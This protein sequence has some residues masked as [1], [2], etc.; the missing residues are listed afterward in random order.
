M[1]GMW[2]VQPILLVT[3]F[4]YAFG[5]AVHLPGITHYIDSL[6]PGVL[7]LAIGFGASQPGGAVAE[8][9]AT[10]MIDRFRSLPIAPASVLA[11]RVAADAVR[12]LFV[13]GLMIA[14]GSAIGFPFHPGPGTA[15]AP[16]SPAPPAGPPF[17]R[18]NPLLRTTPR[19]A[20]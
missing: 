14:A 15:L 8:D 10:G 4:T 9:L 16:V 20:H 18:L 7:V 12:N 5:G 17:S 19:Y 2:T 3:L 6:L 1:P 11:G 13:V